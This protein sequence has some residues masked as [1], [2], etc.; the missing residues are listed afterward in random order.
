M[1]KLVM[2]DGTTLQ[3]YDAIHI[4]RIDSMRTGVDDS[5]QIWELRHCRSCNTILVGALNE[6]DGQR[7][8]LTFYLC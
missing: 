4:V 2:I 7:H 3:A 5:V 6:W 1:E 8:T